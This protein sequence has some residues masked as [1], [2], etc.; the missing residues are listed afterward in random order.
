MS[1]RL[2]GKSFLI[3]GACALALALVPAES[4]AQKKPKIQVPPGG[5]A[6]TNAALES[7]QT[8]A[9]KCNSETQWCP[10]NWC[11]QGKLEATIFSCWEPS[12]VCSPKC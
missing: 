8:C 6:I 4:V 12:G 3:A 11:M 2:V 10:V 9:A 7:G 1:M 5:C